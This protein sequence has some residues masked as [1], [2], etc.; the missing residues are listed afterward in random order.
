MPNSPHT[1]SPC[2]YVHIT[3]GI[4]AK[5]LGKSLKLGVYVLLP[6][7]RKFSVQEDEKKKCFL[8]VLCMN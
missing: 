2:R 5:G 6:L 3:L 7:C 8:S 1:G 4:F